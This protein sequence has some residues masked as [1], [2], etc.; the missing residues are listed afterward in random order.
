MFRHHT[1]ILDYLA[2]P[3]NSSGDHYLAYHSIPRESFISHKRLGYQ[4]LLLIHIHSEDQS[5]VR[6]IVRNF[7]AGPHDPGN[8]VI[9]FHS[10][11]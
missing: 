6:N 5:G 3:A 11:L 8:Q 7:P 10:C 1:V 4:P 9:V 2:A